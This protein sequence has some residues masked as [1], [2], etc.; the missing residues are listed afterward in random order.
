MR[1]L[2]D[3]DRGNLY[4]MKVLKKA[5]LK[6]NLSWL[7]IMFVVARE[8]LVA[9]RFSKCF[10]V[11]VQIVENNYLYLGFKEQVENLSLFA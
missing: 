3:T 2:T 9:L 8:C 4:A 6:G 10:Y 1:K 7:K 11:K 5:T